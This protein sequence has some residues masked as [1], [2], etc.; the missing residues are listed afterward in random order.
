MK[1][2]L[3]NNPRSY[4]GDSLTFIERWVAVW[5]GEVGVSGEAAV[6]AE[7]CLVEYAAVSESSRILIH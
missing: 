7:V 4:L 2:A 1:I 5:V 3:F 6:L